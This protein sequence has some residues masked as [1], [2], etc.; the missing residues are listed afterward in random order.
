MQ[1]EVLNQ[2]S[3]KYFALNIKN[4]MLDALYLQETTLSG[5]G[6]GSASATYGIIFFIQIETV[7]NDDPGTKYVQ[8]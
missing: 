2:Y 7:F 8:Y 1:Y 6:K 4:I 3:V 5:I